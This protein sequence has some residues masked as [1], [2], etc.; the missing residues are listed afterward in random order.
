MFFKKSQIHMMETVLVLIVFFILIVLGFSLY[1]MFFRGS[2]KVE[3]EEILQLGA[4]GIAQKVQFLPE[5]QCTEDNVRYDNCIDKYKL[6]AAADVMDE[7][8][9]YYYDTLGYSKVRFMQVY[10]TPECSDGD[11]N[12]IDGFTD[13]YDEQCTDSSDASE[14]EEGFQWEIYE[15]TLTDPRSTL[16]I[17]LPTIIYDPYATGTCPILGKG[18][19]IF[20][21]L[22]VE[23]Y[24]K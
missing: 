19:C 23:V 22:K 18:S 6:L 7:N 24:G 20:G 14:S 16:T 11:D 10:P 1:A 4:V 5:L 8:V 17:N 3:K 13:S 15:K 12:D 9:L 21:V 2:L